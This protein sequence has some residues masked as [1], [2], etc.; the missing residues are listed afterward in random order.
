[1]KHASQTTLDALEGLLAELRKHESLK[2]KKRGVFYRKSNA[3]LHFHEDH[4]QH[5][6]DLRMGS[7]WVR[8]P[9]NTQSD[10]ETLLA[11]VAIVL[12]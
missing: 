3:F 1:M 8:F 2:E 7:D 11:Q 4:D 9:V 6:A 10:W 12:S 5:F